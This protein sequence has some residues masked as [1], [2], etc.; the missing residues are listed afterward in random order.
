MSLKRPWLQRLW[1]TGQSVAEY[2]VDDPVQL[3][4]QVS[5]RM[6][7]ALRSAAGNS[8]ARLGSAARGPVEA[9][10]RE[11]AGDREAA[12]LSLERN[13]DIVSSRSGSRKARRVIPH[14][15]DLALAIGQPDRARALLEE[16]PLSERR[17]PWY[18]TAAR[19]A[20]YLGDHDA[21][22]EMASRHPYN[23]KLAKRMIGEQEIF[24]G[25]PIVLPVE[26]GYQPEEGRVLH[27]L[28]N[29]LP[30]TG[31]GY[32]QRSHSVLRSLK[33]EGFEVCA[34][35]RPGYPVQ[36]GVPWA[37]ERD[38]VDDITYCRLLPGRLGQGLRERL[39]QFAALLAHE[40]R[41]FRPSMLHTTTHFVNGLV[42]GAVARA[43]GIPW[44][45]EV[46]GQLAD[47]WAATR[48][49]GA[50]ESQ[51]YRQFVERELAVAGAA[52]AVVTL[53]DRMKESL[54]RGGIDAEKISVCPNAVGAPF[55]DE[56]PSRSEARRRLG[57]EADA[58]YVGTVS[59]IV[60]YEGLDLLVRAVARLAP[61]HPRLRLRIAGDGV[62][63]PGLKVLAERLEIAH[64]CDFPG[65]VPRAEAV[66]H[67]AALD[68]FVVPRKD[69]PVTR[70]VTP[71]KS[72]E[73]SAL[74][75]PVIASNLP[76]LEELVVN[77]VTGA[78]FE[79]EDVESL[80][81]SLATLLDAPDRQLRMGEAAR[82][83]AL[84]TRTWTANAEIYSTIYSRLGVRRPGA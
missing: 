13:V 60:D 55:T 81:G 38:V 32:A 21:A 6:P 36:I 18:A 44:V 78:L 67:H 66:W 27:V 9:I 49:P 77:G 19:I 1:L 80:A 53:G 65:R 54:V 84:E 16:L 46:R 26:T 10:G 48:G 72:V 56:P 42:T 12:E 22:V 71:M 70:S 41:E 73:A 17:A 43:F 69:L 45:Y 23:E 58:E 47:T 39:E 33:T 15:A 64:L 50:M 59:S 51:R 11:M 34:V 74:G 63:L 40:V 28:T 31:S 35:T 82:R 61:S 8:L 2:T 20:L 79:P 29:S 24:S 30:H 75:R 57:L 25:Y 76:A 7:P 4:L 83:W 14:L 37:A 68:I 62:A 3:A 5:R 52:D